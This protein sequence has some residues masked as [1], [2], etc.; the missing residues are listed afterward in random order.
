MALSVLLV[1]AT[2]PNLS[3]A[4]RLE[5]VAADL[6]DALGRP[7]DGNGDGQP[8]GNYT[9]TFS[10][11]GATSNGLSLARVRE[12]P[13]TVSV[14]IDALLARGELIGLVRSPQT[15]SDASRGEIIR[16]DRQRAVS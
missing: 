8:G 12:Q 14:A 3:Q 13:G 5:I 10:R 1:P 15:D 7:L 2:K 4:D 11:S 9:A 6:A 16:G